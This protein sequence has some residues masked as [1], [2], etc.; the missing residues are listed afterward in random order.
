MNWIIP[1][2]VYL[3]ISVRLLTF[4]VPMTLVTKPMAMIWRNT[5][6]RG[7]G[8]IPEKMRVPLGACGTIAVILVGAFVSPEGQDNT[9]ANR[10]VSLFGLG[11]FIFVLW[12]TSRNRKAVKWHTLMVGMLT[13]FIIAIFV[14]KSGAGCTFSIPHPSSEHC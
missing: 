8:M 2:L 12:L 4:Y 13:Q 3:A 7:V 11:V 9:R 5:V 14:L 10:A 6:G 1:F